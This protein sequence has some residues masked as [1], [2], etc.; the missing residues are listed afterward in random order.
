MDP[1]SFLI[2]V[3][4]N[5]VAY[6]LQPKPKQQKPASV[7][8]AENPQAEAGMPIP[9]VFGTVTVKGL[10]IM[11]YGDKSHKEYEISV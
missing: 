8:D 10:N 2:A 11:W 1:I 7:Q 9:R 6:L 5:V 3:A 4:L